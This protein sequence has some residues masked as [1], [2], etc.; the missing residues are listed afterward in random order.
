[1]LIIL[2][3]NFGC[4]GKILPCNKSAL[5]K[6]CFLVEE[7]ED[8][9]PTNSPEPL[10]T[11]VNISIQ[12]NDINEVDEDKQALE[13]SLYIILEWQ[14]NRLSVNRSKEDSNK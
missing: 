1:M 13:L 6:V 7:A 10:P 3:R 5:S 4:N 11:M 2:H 12:I 14:D 9:V 8:Y